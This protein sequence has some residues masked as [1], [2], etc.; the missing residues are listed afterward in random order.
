[1]GQVAAAETLLHLLEPTKGYPLDFVIYRIT[2]YRPKVTKSELLTGIAL[3]H[4]LG[5]L[6]E[7]V[8][9]T[10]DLHASELAEPVLA[11]DDVCERFNVTS[12]TIQ[13]WR[14]KGL[15]A[16]R[17]IFPDGKR[18]VGFLLTSVERFVGAHQ[19]QVAPVSNFSQINDAE[20]TL[21]VRHA[22]RLAV[23][24]RCGIDEITHRIARLTNRSPLTI[25]HTLRKHDQEHP[26]ADTDTILPRAAAA[27]P[28][29]D[30]VAMLKAF[31]RG[32]GIAELSARYG[33]PRSSIYRA[34]MTERVH[35][36]LKRK[37]RFHDDPLFHERE[38]ERAIN[39]ILAQDELADE[40]SREDLRVP[41]DLP[42]YLQA[43][44]RTPLL[45]KS[46]ERAL[47]LKLNFYK[48]QFVQARRRLDP[49][50]ARHR[51]LCLL[52]SH[53]AKAGE[54]KNA[55][56]RAN[57]RLV[58]SIARKH[59]RG[60][61]GLLELV[62]EGNITLMRAVESFDVGRGHRFSTY[63]TFALMKGFARTVPQMLTA[64][65]RAGGGDDEMLAQ[66]P[67]RHG[68]VG[69]A[70]L[71]QR[72]ELERLLARL[73]ARERSVVAAHFGLDGSA[74]GATYEQ[75]GL[76]LGLSKERVRQIEQGALAKLRAAAA[77]HS[78]ISEG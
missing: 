42:P 19:E 46:R 67:D 3:Q 23:Q 29:P 62:S 64:S 34:V 59:L 61:L 78:G 17:F 6:I 31:R 37:V 76:R 51:H 57:L 47:F 24:C 48:Y 56:V 26:A 15:P 68:G 38:A 39:M 35:R 45:T 60:N 66:V 73:D 7:S 32:A 69:T 13:R 63:A 14:R 33:R 43:L 9:D 65:R 4:D 22:R 28:E 21:I 52:E 18:R 2:E 77:A 16:R 72:D 40:P 41:R 75:V 20:R 1:M 71:I 11:I 25:L 49:E 54:V 27:V 70:R 74:A 8:S 12:K 5:L 50:A 55:I 10:L 44:Y 53:L 30:R 58:V 36:L